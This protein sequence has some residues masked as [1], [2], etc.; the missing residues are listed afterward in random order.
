MSIYGFRWVAAGLQA[1]GHQAEAA[2]RDPGL[3][4]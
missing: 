2:K 1:E 3:Q 4:T